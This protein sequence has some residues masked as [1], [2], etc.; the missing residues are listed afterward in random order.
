MFSLFEEKVISLALSIFDRRT[1]LFPKVVAFLAVLYLL[2]PFDIVPDVI[3]FAGWLD[4]IIVVPFALRWVY[5]L[6]PQAVASESFARAQHISKKIKWA[7]AIMGVV[8]I[9]LLIW[10]LVAIFHR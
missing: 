6:I 9:A 3:P 5:S 7:V 4:D 1:P 8:A 10:L 2:S